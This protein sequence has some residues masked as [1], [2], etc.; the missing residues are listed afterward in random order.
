MQKQLQHTIH[1]PGYSRPSTPGISPPQLAFVGLGSMGYGT[2]LANLFHSIDFHEISNIVIIYTEI[3]KNLATHK[4]SHPQGSHPLLVWNRSPVKSQKLL[5]ELGP[6]L[7]AIAKDIT[8]VAREA[9]IIFSCLANDEV[10]EDVYQ[11]Y[12]QALTVSTDFSVSISSVCS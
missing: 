9:D 10:I 4:T 1:T 8:Q 6:S 3:A 12:S 11:Q 5:D 7:I 2:V